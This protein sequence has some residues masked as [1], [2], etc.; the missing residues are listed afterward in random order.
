MRNSA[1]NDFERIRP[2]QCRGP[3]P[4]DERSA[5]RS[6]GGHGEWEN[7]RRHENGE[8]GRGRRSPVESVGCRRLCVTTQVRRVRR[9]VGIAIRARRGSICT[10]LSV[11]RFVGE[12]ANPW[13]IVTR[14]GMRGQ[15]IGEAKNPGPGSQ[16]RRTQRLRALQRALDSDSESD[17]ESA[18]GWSL[19]GVARERGVGETFHPH[20]AHVT[21]PTMVDSDDDRPLL[22]VIQ[23]VQDAVHSPGPELFVLSD[24]GQSQAALTGVAQGIEHEGTPS[25]L[26]GEACPM[27]V[28]AGMS[29]QQRI[30]A[31]IM[32]HNRFAELAQEEIP[33]P[34]HTMIGRFRNANDS[35]G[36]HV[37]SMRC[38]RHCAR[39]WC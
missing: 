16:R 31:S 20:G 15:R 7:P 24:D 10:I 29:S 11:V 35:S 39:S 3:C 38:P 33:E 27:R 9:R 5:K 17:A 4:V 30:V 34:G 18:E 32:G 14:Y 26:V 21:Q 28:N 22:S 36:Q 6:A 37:L 8:V 25:V 13:R 1:E 12:A 23:P 19:S 2:S